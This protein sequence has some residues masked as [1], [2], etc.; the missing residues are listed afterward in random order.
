MKVFFAQK[1]PCNHFHGCTEECC[2]V[3]PWMK[4]SGKEA[5]GFSILQFWLLLDQFSAK[6]LRFFGFA[7]HSGLRIVRGS[8][9]DP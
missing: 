1:A 5:L 4:A 8:A 9:F 7:A 2:A 6:K 3:P